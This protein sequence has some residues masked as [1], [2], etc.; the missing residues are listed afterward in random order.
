MKKQVVCDQKKLFLRR[1]FEQCAKR[2]A[3]QPFTCSGKCLRYS[4]E[5]LTDISPAYLLLHLT[6]WPCDPTNS[7]Q[8]RM[9]F[10]NRISGSTKE[11]IRRETLSAEKS[12]K[13]DLLFIHAKFGQFSIK[14]SRLTNKIGYSIFLKVVG[15]HSADILFWKHGNFII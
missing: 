5:T 10:L 12:S 13:Y 8:R 14:Q 11:N 9:E 7:V 1:N 2:F 15:W 3:L 6:P 4:P